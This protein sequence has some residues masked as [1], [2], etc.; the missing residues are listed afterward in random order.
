MIE[1]KNKV[2]NDSLIFA[3]I[4][5]CDYPDF[6]DVYITYAEYEDGTKLTEDEL[7]ILND[8][9]DIWD[10]AFRRYIGCG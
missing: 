2:N 7:D 6:S 1:L 10:D 8:E 9:R 5:T 4:S 3:G